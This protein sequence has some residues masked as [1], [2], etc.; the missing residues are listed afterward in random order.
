MARH[1]STSTSCDDFADRRPA[2]R[3]RL[4]APSSCA[5]AVAVTAD[6]SNEALFSF[7]ELFSFSFAAPS[8]PLV[9]ASPMLS[10]AA[11]IAR[12]LSRPSSLARAMGCGG[13]DSGRRGVSATSVVEESSWSIVFS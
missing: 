6:V 10:I 9:V 4:A 8:P 5:F 13:E 11:S 7:S 12:S 2:E 3:D 1:F